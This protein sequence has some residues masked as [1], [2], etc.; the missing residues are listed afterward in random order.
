M[1]KVFLVILICTSN[2]FYAQNKSILK[3]D[4][5]KGRVKFIEEISI[6]AKE[7]AQNIIYRKTTKYNKNGN[8]ISSIFAHSVNNFEP[9][10]TIFVLNRK[11]VPIKEIRYDLSKKVEMYFIFEIDSLGNL[12]KSSQFWADGRLD[13]YSTFSYNT[14]LEITET[15][16]HY[17][18]GGIWLWFKFKYNDDSKII[19]VLN[20][21]DSTYT[22]NSFDK[23][24]NVVKSVEFDKYGLE[25][26]KFN[27]YIYKYDERS[28][29]TKRT[30]LN[31]KGDLV[32]ID[33]RI[34]QYYK[35]P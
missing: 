2:L 6:N 35:K 7:E 14:K 27:S 9:T 10:K 8:S 25:T 34:Y 1:N 30:Q 20:C 23:N 24:G 32:W 28:N 11:G 21:D 22:R 29:W 17:S 5:I 15:K 4:N 3:Q 33:E 26:G 18:D 12:V 13:S 31:E 19:E 16:V